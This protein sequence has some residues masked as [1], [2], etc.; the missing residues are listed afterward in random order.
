MNESTILFLTVGALAL[1]VG[2]FAFSLVGVYL[3]VRNVKA[4]DKQLDEAISETGFSPEA[5]SHSRSENLPV[6]GYI[7]R[8]VNYSQQLAESGWFNRILDMILTRE[9]EKHLDLKLTRAGWRF[10]FDAREFTGAQLIAGGVVTLFSALYIQLFGFSPVYYLAL[11]LATYMGFRLTE[12]RITSNIEARQEKIKLDL[13]RAVD[14]LSVSVNAGLTLD[15]AFT[16]YIERFPGPLSQEFT[17]MQNEVAIGHRRRDALRGISER[18]G[19]PEVH[20]LISA[21]LQAER[22]GVSVAQI[23]DSQSTELKLRRNQYIREQTQ[24]APVQMLLPIA[25]LIMPALLCIVLGPMLIQMLSGGL[26]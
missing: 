17:Q 20:Q 8:L 10:Y 2:C 11:P 12:A 23:L 7:M 18:T 4:R 14:I 9:R 1:L 19:V 24:K 21:I 25:L 22:F 5:Y 13:P 6:P 15:R 3:L 26:F 16:L